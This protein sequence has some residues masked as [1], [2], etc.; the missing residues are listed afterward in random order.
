MQI[1]C[2]ASDSACDVR[3]SVCGQAFQVYWTRSC[4]QDHGCSAHL[5]EILAA[6]HCGANTGAHPQREFSLSISPHP[7]YSETLGAYA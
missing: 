2:K 1:L 3:C 6:H 7:G 5:Q 4:A